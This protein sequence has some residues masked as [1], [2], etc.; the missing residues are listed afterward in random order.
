MKFWA[1]RQVLSSEWNSERVRDAASSDS[2]E[3]ED[4]ELPCVIGERAG[5][6]VWRGSRRSVGSSFHRQMRDS[7]P[8]IY[9]F[10]HSSVVADRINWFSWRQKCWYQ[11]LPEISEKVSLIPISILLMRSIT[12]TCVSTRKV[13]PLL[14]V[15]MPIQWCQQLWWH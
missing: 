8:G 2:G 15:A 4:D 11:I 14:L 5:D 10:R 7:S 1:K 3:G 12:D 13:S 6:C 9:S